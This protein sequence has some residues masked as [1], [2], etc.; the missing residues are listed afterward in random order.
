MFDYEEKR[1]RQNIEH[2][3]MAK[4]MHWHKYW[5]RDEFFAEARRLAIQ[6]ILIID[7]KLHP[8]YPL[9]EEQTEISFSYEFTVKKK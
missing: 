5:N 7:E 4:N 1:V 6:L 8:A 2:L 3:R 9:I